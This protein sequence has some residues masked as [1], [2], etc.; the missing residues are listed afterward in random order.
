MNFLSH[1]FV[2]RRLFACLALLS[3]AADVAKP[4]D[5]RTT[6]TAGFP[7]AAEAKRMLEGLAGLVLAA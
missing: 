5:A 4:M 3:L 7:N 6:H 2:R 1:R